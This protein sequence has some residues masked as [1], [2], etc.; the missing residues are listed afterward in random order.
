MQAH[1]EQRFGRY[2]GLMWLFA[3]VLMLALGSDAIMAWRLGDPDDQM[4]LVQV[5]DW[6]GG[7]SWWDI[8][9]YRMNPPEGGPMHWSRLVD[10]P[11]AALILF[12]GLFLNSE[13]A[14]LAAC[15]LLPVMTMGLVLWLYAKLAFRLFGASAALLST[16]LLITTPPVITQLM[17]MRID[18]HGWQIVLFLVAANALFSRSKPRIAGAIAGLALALWL[19]ISIEALPFAVLCIG[20]MALQWV[21]PNLSSQQ[22][23]EGK[24]LS[25][26][27][28][29]AVGSIGLFSIT[30]NWQ[31][32]GTHC[33]SL[34]P[35][36]GFCF[37]AIA[38]ILI[39]GSKILRRTKLSVNWLGR[40]AL[41]AV[42]GASGLAILLWLAPQC[43]GDAFN[44]L[45]PLVMTYWFN[46]GPEGLP[47]WE[48]PSV[49]AIP[50]WVYYAIGAVV[51]I[52]FRFIS[53]P[54]AKDDRLFLL[55]L[56]I[57]SAV[58]GLFV[59]RAALYAVAL[60][61]MIA[62]AMFLGIMTQSEHLSSIARR[63]IVRI[64]AIILI[65]PSAIGQYIVGL[66]NDVA[67]AAD[68]RVKAEDK[69]FN[70][71][72]LQ[73]QKASSARAL[74]A[75]PSGS[76][77][78]T[79]LDTAPAVLM[80]TDHKIVATG[81]HRNQHAMADVIRSFVGTE[82]E[83]KNIYKKRG[84]QYLVTCEGSFELQLYYYR[85][86]KGFGAQINKGQLPD[87][88][89]KDQRIG[90]FQIYRVAQNEL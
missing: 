60:V 12:F 66:D 79:A 47:I 67:M 71:L 36:H 90:P 50:Y 4:R 83:A 81:H 69:N 56:L 55:L 57:C 76:Q 77:L 78:M 72:A 34:S 5:R 14:E 11:I 41:C 33:D 53:T 39:A 13:A 19:E 82:A 85:A 10:I 40:T 84:I 43:A 61:N 32:H 21:F 22:N 3:C 58:I 64:L 42:A 75:L 7:Q 51:L 74:N 26:M 8:T 48:L 17:P 29:L 86:P 24:F 89:V 73:C 27:A 25:A 80:F 31:T 52:V 68:P 6:L 62:A 59:S 44:N 16:L 35:V 30:E 37:A 54:I 23:S 1:F 65:I 15:A 63:M 87:W 18:H 20:L 46:R 49:F 88:L 70:Q 38:F 45:D 9:Q 2:I 28:A